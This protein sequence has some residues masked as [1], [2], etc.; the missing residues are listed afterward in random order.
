[1]ID[2]LMQ[3]LKH[4]WK[5]GVTVRD[6]MTKP[7]YYT[8]YLITTLGYKLLTQIIKSNEQNR[9]TMYNYAPFIQKKV[10]CA[11]SYLSINCLATE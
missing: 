7:E 11:V 6:M 1:M 4:T 8:S 5:R 2:V 9:L 3:L 10:P